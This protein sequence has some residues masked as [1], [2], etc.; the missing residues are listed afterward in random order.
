MSSDLTGRT[1]LQHLQT[2]AYGALALPLLLFIYLYLESSVDRL[3][4]LVPENFIVLIFVP[5]FIICGLIVFRI[6]RSFKL[7]KTQ[8]IS[9]EQ[10]REKLN[11]YKKANYILFI[12]YAIA[13]V[14][15]TLGFYVT[16]YQAFAAVFGIM[17]VLFSI[18]NPTAGRIVNDLRL[19]D[20]EKLCIMNGSQIPE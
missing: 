15:C 20:Q 6:N 16:N 3:E 17:L 7:L 8:A 14:I 12:G 18:N 19:K 13:A 2:V 10:F 11:L 5:T 1:Y 9:R 4:A